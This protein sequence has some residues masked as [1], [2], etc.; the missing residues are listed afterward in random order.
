MGILSGAGLSDTLQSSTISAAEGQRV[1]FPTVIMLTKM[2][3]DDTFTMFWALTLVSRAFH[4]FESCL[5]VWKQE[6]ATAYFSVSVKSHYRQM[7]YEILDY[8]A[9]TIKARQR[10]SN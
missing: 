10:L 5:H 9:S 2:R 3:T 8:A 6:N 7:R 1:A 4:I